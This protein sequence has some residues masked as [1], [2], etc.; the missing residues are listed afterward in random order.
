M[1]S[2]CAAAHW[3][4][5]RRHHRPSPPALVAPLG[6]CRREDAQ[7]AGLAAGELDAGKPSGSQ[8][9]PCL[10][11]TD[12]WDRA[13]LEAQLLGLVC[14]QHRVHVAIGFGFVFK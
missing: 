1:P 14:A 10:C 13:D 9:P 12:R 2:A 5:W 6:S 3:C 7:G 4:T 8:R 11:A